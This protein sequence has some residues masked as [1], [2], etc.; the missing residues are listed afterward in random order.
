MKNKEVLN[1]DYIMGFWGAA[2]TCEPDISTERLIAMCCD[3]LEQE[4]GCDYL[5]AHEAV[6]DALKL[7]SEAKA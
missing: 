7:N 3:H 4:T 5:V 1:P 6:M 2:E